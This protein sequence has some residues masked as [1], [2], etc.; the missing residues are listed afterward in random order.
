MLVRYAPASP[1]GGL[2]VIRLH[3]PVHL[4]GERIGHFGYLRAVPRD[5]L[6]RQPPGLV[7]LRAKR[8]ASTYR[9]MGIRRRSSS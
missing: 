2:R 3:R 8:P 5:P 9:Q 6:P 1:A 7:K 4:Q